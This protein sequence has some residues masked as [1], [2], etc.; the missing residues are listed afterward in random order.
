MYTLLGII[1]II[2]KL[3]I[4]YPIYFIDYLSSLLVFIITKINMKIVRKRY[5]I[6]ERNLQKVFPGKDTIELQRILNKSLKIHL[7]NIIVGILGQILYK[8]TKY[9]N[10]IK[11]EIPSDFDPNDF[12]ND[13]KYGILL[14]T[15][16]Y[17][18]FL[19]GALY[20][21]E[22]LNTKTY[23]LYHYVKYLDTTLYPKN[24]YK[25]NHFIRYVETKD[26]EIVTRI[27][28][29]KKQDIIVLGCD[30]RANRSNENV[31]FLNQQVTFH[32]SPASVKL[33]TNK[34][35]WSYHFH[36]DEKTRTSIFKIERLK[37]DNSN[38]L[39]SIT[40]EVADHLSNYIIKNP[41]QYLWIHD[42]FKDNQNT[43][44]K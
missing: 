24:Y 19:N 31:K 15:S 3:F 32:T 36:Y 18:I 33:Y 4:E 29:S 39:H 44:V 17:G 10:T 22:L 21:G 16:H 35:L 26:R 14:L 42:R 34:K 9:K 41:E 40:Q 30:Q 43:N 7:M 23:I 2:T 27:L 38:S 1:I 11:Y 5:K 37:I 6:A 28:K 8:Y 20:L 13:K 12:E 25:N